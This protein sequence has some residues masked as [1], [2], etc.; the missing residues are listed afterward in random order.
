MDYGEAHGRVGENQPDHEKYYQNNR[1]ILSKLKY[2]I[3]FT[4]LT[5]KSL[6]F[7]RMSNVNNMIVLCTKSAC[8]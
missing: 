6:Y 8:K 1:K 3:G 5:I 2:A 7:K 4:R